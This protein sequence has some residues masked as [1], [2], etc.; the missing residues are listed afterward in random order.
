MAAD[1]AQ[2][3]TGGK[4]SESKSTPSRPEARPFAYEELSV[5]Q[6]EAC[7]KLLERIDLAQ[8]RLERP[9]PSKHEKRPHIDHFRVN[10]LAFLSGKR[11]S[12][13]TSVLLSLADLFSGGRKDAGDFE[14]KLREY[15]DLWTSRS[16][17]WLE[18]LDLEP[19]ASSSNLLASILVRIEDA[20][21]SELNG[22]EPSGRSKAREAPYDYSSAACDL[23]SASSDPLLELRRL[24]R[25]VAVVWE[26]NLRERAEHLD[27]DDFAVE[28]LRGERS[29][30]GLN[31][32]LGRVLDLLAEGLWRQRPTRELIFLLPIDDFDVEPLKSLELLHLLRLLSQR[33]LF[34]IICGDVEIAEKTL[35][36][37]TAGDLLA[38]G[39]RP[40]SDR[41]LPLPARELG[42]IAGSIGANALRKLIPPGNR[43]L[44]GPMDL[45]TARKYSPSSLKSKEQGGDEL[46]KLQDLLREFPVHFNSAALDGQEQ[47]VAKRS[48]MNLQDFLLEE[49]P[50]TTRWHTEGDSSG[51]PNG[52]KPFYP[53]AAL[54]S[55][56]PR[57]VADFWI[58]LHLENVKAE[59]TNW[60]SGADIEELRRKGAID[61]FVRKFQD[62]I[63]EDPNLSPEEKPAIIEALREDFR[64]A[65]ELNTKAISIAFD[66]GPEVYF[67]LRR[68]TKSLENGPETSCRVVIAEMKDW[69]INP[70]RSRNDYSVPAEEE[71]RRA[72]LLTPRFSD[73][74]T[75]SLFIVHDL[76]ALRRPLGLIGH[77]LVPDP[78]KTVWAGA[79]WSVGP[80]RRVR[81]PWVTPYWSSFWEF[82]LFR[83]AWNEVVRQ[84]RMMDPL[85]RRPKQPYLGDYSFSIFYWWL[86][87]IVSILGKK[88]EKKGIKRNITPVRE[89]QGFRPPTVEM[90]QE[91]FTDLLSL[92]KE[93][94]AGTKRRRAL[95]LEHFLCHVV[96]AFAPESGVGVRRERIEA[97]LGRNPRAKSSGRN[98]VAKEP[99]SVLASCVEEIIT[100][101]KSEP[102]LMSHVRAIR[103]SHAAA[104]W[105]A[106]ARRQS[107][108]MVICDASLRQK[109][110]EDIYVLKKECPGDFVALLE[111]KAGSVP[112]DGA[113]NSSS[114][115][116][117]K[118]LAS[119]KST[120]GSTT[121]GA[122][123][124]PEERLLQ[125]L[126]DVAA[127]LGRSSKR[128]RQYEKEEGAISE[129]VD[130]LLEI[131]TTQRDPPPDEK[132]RY[133]IND[134]QSH[135]CPTIEEVKWASRLLEED[136]PFMG[137]PGGYIHAG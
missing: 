64:G 90:I 124:K 98:S 85:P 24:Q 115:I 122:E 63:R 34:T 38:T 67:P 81:I 117:E 82:S 137:R 111:K 106:E 4:S 50:A 129:R 119:L 49:E 74:A 134:H 41:F 132:E 102:H 22:W 84:A 78:F 120:G 9:D 62:A 31:R 118:L 33:R 25:S 42:G 77:E 104:F 107:Y 126:R 83:N 11:G 15:K 69:D 52:Q 103:A 135:F 109:I 133:W 114:D 89:G 39:Q 73:Q 108:V 80:G 46:P 100:Y 18:T 72:S 20:I 60:K 54:L 47:V 76:L 93:V 12:G 23:T 55:A 113:A 37:K 105:K 75:A 58:G 8:Q 21:A 57:Q 112:S 70:R 92:K 13:K 35:N 19:M 101:C 17:I 116:F 91:V 88:K 127:D 14:E 68:K 61:F 10:N 16:V 1:A 45:E 97:M 71:K 136:R 94:E 29:R 28:V 87:I 59:R 2:E 123:A 79:I 128:L 7:K 40:S 48:V 53:G 130:A 36:L 6:Q 125:Y 30:L 32:N 66:L 51:K 95:L 131:Q 26:G 43:I 65:W 121:A 27:P 86:R 56:A 99:R 5:T 44:I 110:V 3:N 96:C